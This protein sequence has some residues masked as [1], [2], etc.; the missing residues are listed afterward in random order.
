MNIFVARQPIFDRKQAVVAYELL[1]RSGLENFFRGGDIDHA[2]SRVISDTFLSFG[3]EAMTGSKR[4]YINISREVLVSDCAS[5]LPKDNVVIELLESIAPD[6]TVMNACRLLKRAGYQIALDDFEFSEEM[7][8]LLQLADIVKVDFIATPIEQ[9]T[10]LS[11]R[12]RSMPIEL[13][14]EKVET[15]EDFDWALKAGYGLFQG[16]FFSK[17]VIIIGKD[18]PGFKLNYIRLLSEINDPNFDFSRLES[19]IKT[20]V[21]ISYKLLRYINSAAFGFRDEI[22]SIRDALVLLGEMNI[23]KLASL[24]L[25]AG[26]GQDKPEELVVC[27]VLRAR[28]CESLAPLVGQKSRQPELF[29]LGMFS[30]IDA[31]VDRPMPE[32]LAQLPISEDINDALLGKPNALRTVLDSVIAYEKGEWDSLSE[33]AGILGLDEEVIPEIYLKSIEW[34]GHIF[35]QGKS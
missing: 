23:R 12:L 24:W 34:T 22:R 7:L 18:V 6:E 8:Q 27:S 2:S 32:I 21:S 20:D 3:M 5:L 16:Y 17:P 9:R 14:A 29:L 30:L 28:F 1:F 33:A 31:I 26:L 35:Q 11:Q 25:L 4:A 19:V 13:L 10:A 15:V